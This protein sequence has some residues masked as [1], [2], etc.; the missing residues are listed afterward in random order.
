MQRALLSLA[1][2]LMVAPP[3]IRAQQPAGETLTDATLKTVLENMGYTVN[4]TKKKDG[5]S[6]FDVDMSIT[7][8]TVHPIIELSPSKRYIWIE[9]PL[10]EVPANAA[11]F[12]ASALLVQNDTIGPYFFSLNS[13]SHKLYLNYPILN[14]GVTPATVKSAMDGSVSVLNST[15]ALWDPSKWKG[16]PAPKK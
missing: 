13:T 7:D 15:S 8:Y 6:S 3:A 4:E 12:D 2:C 10:F 1:L 11:G 9:I 5:T 16:A 14:S